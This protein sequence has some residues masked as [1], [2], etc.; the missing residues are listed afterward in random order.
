MWKAA[1]VNPDAY[2]QRPDR[3]VAHFERA[4]LNRA[5]VLQPGLQSGTLDGFG[6]IVD[7]LS[8]IGVEVHLWVWC[9]EFIRNEYAFSGQPSSVLA[10]FVGGIADLLEQFPRLS[11][12]QPDGIRVNKYDISPRSG[13]N[14][15]RP[16]V[17]E[18]ITA[19]V[20]SVMRAIREVTPGYTMT[21]AIRTATYGGDLSGGPYGD[22]VFWEAGTPFF[23]E[24]QQDALR[25]LDE[26]W[27]DLLVP[28][29]YQARWENWLFE[30]DWWREHGDPSKIVMGVGWC[31]DRGNY[32]IA[33]QGVRDRLA[34]LD[35]LA[36]FSV[37]QAMQPGYDDGLEREL[38]QVLG[39][40]VGVQ[41]DDEVWGLA[42]DLRGIADR[43]DRI[44]GIL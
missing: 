13:P 32:R 2:E 21:A 8:D 16:M 34:A 7:A 31:P 27:V 19:A 1:W 37:F 26:G 42:R 44:A 39:E 28:M 12:V 24:V 35:G 17:D 22:P 6:H 41:L 30:V 23:R 9:L 43:L 4:G 15:H 10:Q 14:A 38:E 5:F 36:G 18:A 25:W 40:V 29:N 11:G 33:P 3:V 20:S